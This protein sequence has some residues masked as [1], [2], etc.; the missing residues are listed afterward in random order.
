MLAKEWTADLLNRE[1]HLLSQRI[2]TSRS[3]SFSEEIAQEVEED[4]NPGK[5]RRYPQPTHMVQMDVPVENLLKCTR[6]QEYFGTTP[7]HPPSQHPLPLLSEE[8]ER[9]KVEGTP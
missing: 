8:G 4:R 6:C 9:R 3:L 7:P 5:G 1:G 2:D